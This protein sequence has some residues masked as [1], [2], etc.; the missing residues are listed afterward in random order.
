MDMTTDGQGAHERSAWAQP[1]IVLTANALFGVLVVLAIVALGKIDAV[2]AGG[3]SERAAFLVGLLHVAFG[4]TAAAVRASAPFLH[5]LD[6]ADDVRQQ[7]RALLLGAIILIAAGSSLILLS[8][9]GPGRLLPQSAALA[10]WLL[11]TTIVAVLAPVRWRLLDELDR[12]LSRDTARLAASL[13]SLVGGT[14][15]TLAHLGFVGAPAP[16]DWLTMF[17]GFGFV[18]GMV[19]LARRGGLT[20]RA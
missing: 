4:I 1:A 7:G 20:R 10:G 11:L 3:I 18:A 16:L 9:A 14:W 12:A 6:E 17:A 8:L 15:A 5:D 19:E 13:I 2:R